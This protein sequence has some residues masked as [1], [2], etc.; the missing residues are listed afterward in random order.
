MRRLFHSAS[1]ALAAGLLALAAA[2][3]AQAAQGTLH[4][5]GHQYANPSGCYPVSSGDQVTNATNERATIHAGGICGGAADGI[6][7]PGESATV[8]GNE[9]LSLYIR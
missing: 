5:G 8:L 4:I 7:D 3:P 2:T 9:G 1:T 6:V